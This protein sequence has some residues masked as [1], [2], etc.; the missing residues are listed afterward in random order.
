MNV[1]DND[2]WRLY[3]TLQVALM[4]SASS[5]G[6]DVSMLLV[7]PRGVG[8]STLVKAVVTRLGIHLY[9]VGNAVPFD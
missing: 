3:R 9:E 6:L 4:H 7:G 5:Y 8:K 1:D 2:Y